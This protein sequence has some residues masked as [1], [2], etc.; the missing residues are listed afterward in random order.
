MS[1]LLAG[2]AIMFGFVSGCQSMSASEE[3]EYLMD[4]QIGKPI[5]NSWYRDPDEKKQIGGGKVEYIIRS[6]KSACVWSF[7]VDENKGV[8]LSWR[9]ISDP[10]VCRLHTS[11]SW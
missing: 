6:K 8:I 3:F 10:S 4:R 7:L 2:F 11:S 1:R 9:Y 5:A